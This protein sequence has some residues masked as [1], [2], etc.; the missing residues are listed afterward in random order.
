MSEVNCAQRVVCSELDF[1]LYPRGG[2][3]PRK[4]HQQGIGTR[5]GRRGTLP[6]I[7]MDLVNAPRSELI[8]ARNLWIANSPPDLTEWIAHI[9]GLSPVSVR[10]V[11][12]QTDT[13]RSVVQ[14]L[15]GG[16]R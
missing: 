3:T 16:N 5:S 2:E 1:V 10:I 6:A 12:W 7:V 15:V 4:D 11:R 13:H 14:P 9:T 8:R